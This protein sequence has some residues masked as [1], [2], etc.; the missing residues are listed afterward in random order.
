M[1]GISIISI[2]I[3]SVSVLC[4]EFFFYFLE[5][6]VKLELSNRRKK[7]KKTLERFEDE[8]FEIVFNTIE[9]H[10]RFVLS[11]EFFLEL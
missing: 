8:R 10:L 1:L 4:G 3:E 11:K 2:I 5:L 6:L 7:E 9:M